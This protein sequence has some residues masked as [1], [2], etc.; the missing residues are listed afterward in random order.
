MDEELERLKRRKMLELR[1]KMMRKGAEAEEA[2]P[3]E[4]PSPR[5]IL[6]GRFKGRAWEVYRAAEAQFPTV[7][8]QIEKALVEGIR[9]GKISDC[10]DGESLFRFLRQV[11]LPV[12]LQTH[13]RY[14]EHGELKTI[15]QRMKEE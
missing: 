10:I 1:R 13:I 7:M 4:E 11:G 14:K 2:E 8:P 3:R 6:D 9:Q 12:R 15:G 5:E